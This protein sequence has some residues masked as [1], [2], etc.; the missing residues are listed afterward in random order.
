MSS[1]PLIET[2]PA[3]SGSPAS[4]RRIAAASA[5]A[6]PDESPTIAIRPGSIPDS[7]SAR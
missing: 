3:G 5:N 7:T 1:Q 6:A 4:R 2:I